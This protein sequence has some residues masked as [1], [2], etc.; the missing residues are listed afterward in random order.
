M[1]FYKFVK[2]Q[3]QAYKQAIKILLVDDEPD[4]RE[5]L[6]YNLKKQGFD[7]YQSGNGV[8]ALKVSNTIKPHFILLDVIMPEMDGIQACKMF[9]QNTDLRQSIIAFFTAHNESFAHA[10]GFSAGADDYIYK[11]SSPAVV[12]AR[13]NALL[14][15]YV[16]TRYPFLVA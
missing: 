3:Q 8:E 4:V 7:V 15:K 12:V 14:E 5:F 16:P 6:S 9:R 13:I 2:M 10:E 11:P 1:H